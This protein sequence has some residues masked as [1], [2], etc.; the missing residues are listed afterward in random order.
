M[1]SFLLVMSGY[2]SPYHDDI[3][4]PVE[5]IKLANPIFPTKQPERSFL[6]RYSIFLH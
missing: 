6:I 1:L 3:I 4:L 2:L 5:P